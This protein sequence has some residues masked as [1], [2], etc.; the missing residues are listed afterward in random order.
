MYIDLTKTTSKIW[1]VSDLHIDHENIIRHSNRPWENIL[2]MNSYI[3]KELFKDVSEEDYIFDLGDTIWKPSHQR[4]E[5]VMSWFN[6]KNI[7][8]I[9]GNHDKKIYSKSSEKIKEETQILDL[10]VKLKDTS[11]IILVLSHYPMVSWNHKFRG[12]INLHGHCHGNI[13]EYNLTSKDLRFDI[14]FDSLNVNYKLLELSDI[15]SL[16]S[17]KI[18]PE[19]SLMK[20]IQNNNNIF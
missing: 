10:R 11:E 16:V 7:Y 14:S 20:W 9:Q 6:S 18:F 2:E 17:S 19:T 5:K 4:V 13:D 3:E 12:S 8:K 15:L 1:F